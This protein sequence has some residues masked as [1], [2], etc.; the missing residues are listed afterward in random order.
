MKSPKVIKNKIQ[1]GAMKRTVDGIINVLMQ[2][3]EADESGM[4]FGNFCIKISEMS[5]EDFY[6]L[7]IA[8][9]N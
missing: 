1:Q 2:M 4:D 3:Y 9:K 6:K 5:P 8:K 7:P